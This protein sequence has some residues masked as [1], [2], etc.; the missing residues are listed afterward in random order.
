MIPNNF[1]LFKIK[2]G[3]L[4]IHVYVVELLIRVFLYV[5]DIFSSCY[6]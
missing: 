2:F 1:K 6:F 5:Y 3:V 4:Y